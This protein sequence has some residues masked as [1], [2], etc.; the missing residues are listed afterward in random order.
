MDTSLTAPMLF[1]EKA[2]KTFQ[3]MTKQMTFS[4]IGA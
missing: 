1:V 3:Q 2:S 4:V